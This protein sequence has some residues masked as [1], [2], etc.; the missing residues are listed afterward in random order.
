M[1]SDLRA[2][3]AR[4]VESWAHVYARHAM[5]GAAAGRILEAQVYD[6]R[7]DFFKQAA[8][9]MRASPEYID[10]KEVMDACNARFGPVT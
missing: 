6:M 9:E 10:P 4:I 3:A 1:A 5:V 8:I 7:S 2:S